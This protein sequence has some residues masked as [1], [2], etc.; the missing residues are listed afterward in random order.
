METIILLAVS[1]CGKPLAKSMVET[2]S[3]GNH[4]VTDKSVT[5]NPVKAVYI[6]SKAKI[7]SKLKIN[8]VKPTNYLFSIGQVRN[9]IVELRENLLWE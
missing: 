7:M 6:G 4:T 1:K 8:R 2:Q 5:R 9:I 3:S